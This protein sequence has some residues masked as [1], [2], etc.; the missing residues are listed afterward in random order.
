[1]DYLKS[2]EARLFLEALNGE[3]LEM[4][5][6]F[7]LATG[8][9]LQEYCALQ[10]KDIDFERGT[11]TVRRALVWHRTGGGYHFKQPKIGK[12]RE[13]YL[14]ARVFAQI[15]SKAPYKAIRAKA[16]AWRSLE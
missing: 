16:K 5:F 8:M 1:M 14:I 7:A 3:R 6:S 12:S 4:M 15:A 9:R 2:D 11:A 10:W 13:L